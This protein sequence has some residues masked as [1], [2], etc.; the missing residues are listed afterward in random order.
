MKFIIN[1]NLKI[2]HY[3]SA[4]SHS[5]LI[6]ANNPPPL[7]PTKYFWSCPQDKTIIHSMILLMVLKRVFK[8]AGFAFDS[9]F[10]NAG[11]LI[12]NAGN[13]M[14]TSLPPPPPPPIKY[15]LY[16]VVA[17]IEICVVTWLL[18]HSNVGVPD[19]GWIFSTST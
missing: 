4:T 13:V 2:T 16:I 14:C 12:K 5:V 1:P 9:V 19:W 8:N 17:I 18:Q 10:K 7:F 15:I 6:N 3:R 11:S